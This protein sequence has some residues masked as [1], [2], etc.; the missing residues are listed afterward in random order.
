M[1]K[2]RKRIIVTLEPTYLAGIVVA[3]AGVMS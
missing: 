1:S 3:I 2:T